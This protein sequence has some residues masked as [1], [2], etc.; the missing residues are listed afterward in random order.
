MESR[1]RGPERQ[2]HGIKY[3]SSPEC[4]PVSLVTFPREPSCSPGQRAR[5]R[6]EGRGLGCSNKH[7][8]VG[9]NKYLWYLERPQEPYLRIGRWCIDVKRECNL[10]PIPIYIST[11][12]VG[13]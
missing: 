11:A 1:T 12:K 8:K 7:Q 9:V 13:K 3:Q 10:S 2:D 6:C 5:M 4:Q